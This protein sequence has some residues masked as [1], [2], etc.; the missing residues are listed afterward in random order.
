MPTSTETPS[1]VVLIKN[2]RVYDQ[3]G[4]VNMP[5]IA[6]VLIVLMLTASKLGIDLQDA[7]RDTFNAKSE[8]MGFPERFD[9]LSGLPR[10]AGGDTN[11]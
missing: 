7:V 11:G 5:A 9:R 4:D 6:D 2:G 1:A 8:Q 10:E 3:H